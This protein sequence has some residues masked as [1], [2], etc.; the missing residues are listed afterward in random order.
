M[1]TNKVAAL[2]PC[3]SRAVGLLLVGALVLAASGAAMAGSGAGQNS[4]LSQNSILNKDSNL[5]PGF[6]PHVLGGLVRRPLTSK[7]YTRLRTQVYA[8]KGGQSLAAAQ[9]RFPTWTHTEDYPPGNAFTYTMVGDNPFTAQQNPTVTIPAPVIGLKFVFSD[10]STTDATATASDCGQSQSPVGLALN[11]PIFQNDLSGTQYVDA[12]QRAN[13]NPETNFSGINPNYHVLL[14]GTNAT[15][16]TLHVPAND[17][18]SVSDS[19]GNN[20]QALFGGVDQSWLDNQLQ[21]TMSTL[22][23]VSPSTFPI[24]LMYNTVLCDSNSCGILGYHATVQANVQTYA[25]A[26]Y[27]LADLAGVTNPPSD[28]SVLSHEVGDWMDDPFGSN[29]VPT[30]GYVGQDLNSDGTGSCQPNLEVADPLTGATLE[31]L[32]E[33]STLYHVQ[34]LAFT[35]WFFRES[36]SL[37]QNGTYS[38]YRELPTPS[39]GTVCPAQPVSVTASP[40]DGRATVSWSLPARS[41]R[42]DGYAICSYLSPS[43][44]FDVSNPC[45]SDSAIESDFSST[46]TTETVTGLNDGISYVF[47]VFAAHQA[48]VDPTNGQP[49]VDLS[50]PSLPSNSV[51][52]SAISSTTTTTTTT[53]APTTTLPPPSTTPAFAQ[54]YDLV[55][56]DGGIFNFGSAQFEGSMGGSALDAPVVGVA[57]DTRTGGYWE[58]A[59][60]GGVFAFNAPFY[61]SMGG[62]PLN[63]PIVG[64]VSDNLTGGYWMVASDGGVFAFNAPFYGSMG[65]SPLNQPIVGMAA[66]PFG[67]GYWL[68]A[69]DGGVFAFGN[70]P[71]YGS[72]GGIQLDKPIVG[73]ASNAFGNGYWLVASDGGVFSFGS[74]HFYGSM[75]GTPLNEPIVGMA[76]A[77]LGLGYWIVARDGG[78]F[79]F[80]D[81]QFEGSMGGSY[82]SAPVVGMAS[83]G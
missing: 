45:P 62:T 77:P 20:P 2:P 42:V 1:R 46:A 66:M 11:S 30:W 63:A 67:T 54:G 65:G 10:G 47:R 51:T 9:A 31:Q 55:A 56:A 50:T 32:Q 36:P 83:A 59:S 69:K 80:G 3:A 37:A 68:V 8:Y 7:G 6:N 44:N 24:F 76:R 78:P 82:L 15:T 19:C 4:N 12:F 72:T 5:Q 79:S 14:S 17:G 71:F 26:D 28:V 48:G 35:S 40:G 43:A 38:F 29:T 53:T 75:G 27:Q 25:V 33:G 41:S 16:L 22:A 13:F 58:V 81:A 70:A 73:M 18:T 60:D 74:A 61:G 57:N 49:L 34:D 52:P 64:M 39:D 23:G 21:S